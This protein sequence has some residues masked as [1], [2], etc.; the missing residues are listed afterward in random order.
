[1]SDAVLTG[2]YA[3]EKKGTVAM[4]KDLQDQSGTITPSIIKQLVPFKD[5]IIQTIPRKITVTEKTEKTVQLEIKPAKKQVLSGY[6]TK[7]DIKPGYDINKAIQDYMKKTG[8]TSKEIKALTEFFVDRGDVTAPK[9]KS[10]GIVW[11]I[12]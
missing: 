8:L 2:L 4:D 6:P 9:Y 11:S 12:V 10:N 7:K 3:L 1:M 5:G